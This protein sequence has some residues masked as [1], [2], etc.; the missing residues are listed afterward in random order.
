MVGGWSFVFGNG[1]GRELLWSTGW[2]VVVGC[3]GLAGVGLVL[4]F[5]GILGVVLL[6]RFIVVVDLTWFVGWVVLFLATI[7]VG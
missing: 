4:L 6:V 1:N 2:V 3:L 5:M 7:V